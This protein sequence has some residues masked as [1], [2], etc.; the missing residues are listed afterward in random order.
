MLGVV[1]K[2][3]GHPGKKINKIKKRHRD[4]AVRL[5]ACVMWSLQING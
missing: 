3:A 5:H 4:E 2:G 1:A